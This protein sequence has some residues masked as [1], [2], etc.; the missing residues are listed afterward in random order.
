M[1]D[2]ELNAVYAQALQHAE[3]AAEEAE[4]TGEGLDEHAP[5]ARGRTP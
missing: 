4:E 2:A 3:V 1:L 5:Q